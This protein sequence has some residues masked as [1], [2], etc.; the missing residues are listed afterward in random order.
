M[1]YLG[2]DY[3][4]KRVG[5]A[6]SDFES[7]I[8]IPKEV[9]KNDKNLVENIKKIVKANLVD[10]IVVGESLDYKGKHNLLMKKILPFK[11]KLEEETGLNVVFESEFMSSAQA[12]R[13]QGKIK[14]LDASAAAIIL[15]SYLDR[16]KQINLK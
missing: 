4:T 14:K 7:G 6:F 15:Q 1:R 13:V 11:K 12:E 16:I 8:A 2:I 9:L 3:G 10:K 5:I